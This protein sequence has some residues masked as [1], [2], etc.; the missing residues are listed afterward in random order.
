MRVQVFSSVTLVKAQA[1]TLKKSGLTDKQS[2]D[3]ILYNNLY[4]IKEG[5]Q[6]AYI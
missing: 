3:I 5:R 4:I 6:N 2:G 1:Q